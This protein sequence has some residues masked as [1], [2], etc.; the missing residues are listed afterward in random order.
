MNI[1]RSDWVRAKCGG[2]GVVIRVARD[3]S[4]ADV[5]WRKLVGPLPLEWSKRMPTKSLTVLHTIPTP[6]GTVT[7]LT[8]ER[9]L[10]NER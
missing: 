9:E 1:E 5:R 2:I 4:W 6:S 8:R 10:K 3:G 7:D